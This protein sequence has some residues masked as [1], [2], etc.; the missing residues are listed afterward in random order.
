MIEQEKK[1]ERLIDEFKESPKTH[2]GWRSP[3]W[4]HF[5]DTCKEELAVGHLSVGVI[6]FG[7]WLMGQLFKERIEV[8]QLKDKVEQLEEKIDDLHV[9]PKEHR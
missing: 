1:L 3:L 8:E 4:K 9:E 7:S 6:D 2:M 5:E